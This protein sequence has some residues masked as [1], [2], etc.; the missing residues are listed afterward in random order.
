MFRSRFSHCA[1]F[2]FHSNGWH[3]YGCKQ[4]F[5][6]LCGW[7]PRYC[8]KMFPFHI[9]FVRFYR[10]VQFG[11]VASISAILF[12][13]KELC[14]RHLNREL[15]KE[16]MYWK[17]LQCSKDYSFDCDNINIIT[18]EHSTHVVLTKR[19][20]HLTWHALRLQQQRRNKIFFKYI[21]MNGCAVHGNCNLMARLK[22]RARIRC[23]HTNGVNANDLLHFKFLCTN[24]MRQV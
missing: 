15:I 6:R 18:T 7:H 5:D 4:I 1:H 9:Y 21:W 24:W 19:S 14:N 20:P 11:K 12:T 23:A 2:L 17:G 22:A 10:I 16:W 13:E 3:H 8:R